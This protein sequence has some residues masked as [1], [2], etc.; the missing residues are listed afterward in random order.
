MTPHPTSPQT[1]TIEHTRQV[2]A[3]TLAGRLPLVDRL[4]LGEALSVLSD[5]HPPYPP[6]P[7]PGHPE[8]DVL[9]AVQDVLALLDLAIAHARDVEEVIRCGTTARILREHWAQDLG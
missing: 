1:A 8:P 7:E 2:M 3:A 4:T 6:L 5:V 9:A